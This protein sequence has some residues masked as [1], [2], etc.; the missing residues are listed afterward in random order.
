V[1]ASGALTDVFAAFGGQL[2]PTMR[3]FEIVHTKSFSDKIFLSVGGHTNKHTTNK[4][5]YTIRQPP[6]SPAVSLRSSPQRVGYGRVVSQHMDWPAAA[7]TGTSVLGGG[8]GRWF[9]SIIRYNQ[10][11]T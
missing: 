4:P 9:P 10:Y 6:V 1:G 11:Y 3:T 5:T 7:H 2:K 8:W